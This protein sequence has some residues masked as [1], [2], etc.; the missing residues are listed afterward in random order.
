MDVFDQIS[1]LYSNLNIDNNLTPDEILKFWLVLSGIILFFLF[2]G[3]LTNKVIIYRNYFDLT[4][5]ISFYLAPI[6]SFISIAFIS[7]DNIDSYFDSE[8]LT[9][10][11]IILNSLIFIA[12]IIMIFS[13][14]RTFLFSIAD[15]GLILGLIIG[16]SKFIIG[17]L[18]IVC[19]VGLIGYLFRDKRKLGHTAIFFIF[20][21]FLGWIVKTLVNGQKV[22]EG[23]LEN[24]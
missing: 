2:L 6:F 16:F 22:F 11:S 24:N 3:A 8:E 21:G 5:S 10:R 18:I 9:T 17:L 12:G 15:N 23:S 20:F 19:M 1:S 4:W 7:G 13:V 14:V